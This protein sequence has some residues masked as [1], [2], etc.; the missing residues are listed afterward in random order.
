M[1]DE[2]SDIV[3]GIDPGTHHCGW[4]LVARRGTRFV[5]IAHGVIHAVTKDPLPARLRTV[6]DGIREVLQSYPVASGAI[7]QAFVYLDPK[8]ALFIGHARG[9]VMVECERIG[10]TLGEY[11]PTVVKRSVVGTGKA[12]KTQVNSMIRVLLGLA[13]APPLD[14]SDALAV[15]ICHA[16]AMAYATQVQAAQSKALAVSVRA[17]A[18]VAIKR[19]SKPRRS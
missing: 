5:H 10:V 19:A 8:A 13:Q 15:A 11:A 1:S 2:P 14:A 3:L 12:D 4:G 18:T 16:S 7:E 9:A 17:P 6:A